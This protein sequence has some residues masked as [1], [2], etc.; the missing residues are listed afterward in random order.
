[1]SHYHSPRF[2][3]V[4]GIVKEFYMWFR[5]QRGQLG[6]SLCRKI[7]EKN[8][9][10]FQ[11][12]QMGELHRWEAQEHSPWGLNNWT[13]NFYDGTHTHD[14]T[15]TIVYIYTP[16]KFTLSCIFVFY[17]FILIKWHYYEYNLPTFTS[18]MLLYWV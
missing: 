7:E 11:N 2:P 12:F 18:F 8:C 17:F 10:A 16:L 14:A 5:T 3:R 4:Q 15:H 1:M 13:W 6:W 9:N